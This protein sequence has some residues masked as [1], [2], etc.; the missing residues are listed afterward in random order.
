ML[1]VFPDKHGRQAFAFPMRSLP[2]AMH[3]EWLDN[4]LASSCRS[5]RLRGWRWLD[6]T[7]QKIIVFWPLIIA[8]FAAVHYLR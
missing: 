8:M 1:A 3:A 4:E 7:T 6:P 5:G 2:S